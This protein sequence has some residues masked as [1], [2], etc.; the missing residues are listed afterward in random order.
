M[1]KTGIS[2]K[3]A[4]MTTRGDPVGE[5]DPDQH[6]DRDQ[7]GQHELRQVAG[8]VGVQAVQAPGGQRGDLAGRAAAAASQD[9]PSRS[10]WS[11]SRRR[12]WDFTAA[13]ARSAVTSPP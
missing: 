4:A 10:A 2:G 6:G 7:A 13:A 12:S 1:A 5:R 9:G 8:E 3:V 11:V